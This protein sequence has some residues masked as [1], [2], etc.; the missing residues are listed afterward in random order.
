MNDPTPIPSPEPT[1]IP[2]PAPEPLPPQL[3]ELRGKALIASRSPWGTLAGGVIGWIVAR[4][5][6]D[7]DTDT[8]SMIAGLA[9]L[10]AAYA[11]RYITNQPITGVLDEKPTPTP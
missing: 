4:Y 9:V 8:S 1:P 5:G 6:L 11:M 10:A 7:L 2:T 3:E